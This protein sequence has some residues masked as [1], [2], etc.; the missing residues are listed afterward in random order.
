MTMFLATVF[1]AWA[2]N[3][4]LLSLLK[5]LVEHYTKIMK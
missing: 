5:G 1:K 2:Q 3:M 4:Y